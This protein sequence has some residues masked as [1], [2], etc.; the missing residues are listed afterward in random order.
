M[1]T[2]V[3][4]TSHAAVR[5]HAATRRLDSCSHVTAGC[6]NPSA[7]SCR[8]RVQQQQVHPSLAQ[9]RRQHVAAS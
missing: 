5:P 3:G 8:R 6:T 9:R 2:E 1:V 4:C 7:T